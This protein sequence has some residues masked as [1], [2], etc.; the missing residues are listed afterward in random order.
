MKSND[1]TPAQLNVGKLTALGFTRKEIAHELKISE[2][3]V[4]R[5]SDNYSKR[6]G[7]KNKA[8]TTRKMI[9]KALCIEE[10]EIL[11]RLVS[12]TI[13]AFVLFLGWLANETGLIDGVKASLSEITNSLTNL[14]K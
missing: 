11:E 7:A 14:L 12:L 3:T 13:I 4:C 1:I 2:K 9:A 8:D 5:H 6:T 10:S